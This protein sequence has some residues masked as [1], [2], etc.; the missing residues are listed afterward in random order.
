[1]YRQGIRAICSWL[2]LL[3][4]ILTGCAGQASPQT[5]PTITTSSESDLGTVESEVLLPDGQGTGGSENVTDSETSAELS[6]VTSDQATQ[7]KENTSSAIVDT[8]A[9]GTTQP[10]SAIA[11]T[12]IAAT[13][14]SPS[15]T[16]KPTTPATTSQ[17]TTTAKPTTPAATS[18]PSST[19]TTTAD[20]TTIRPTTRPTAA[21]S[22]TPE[23]TK[24]PYPLSCNFLIDCNNAVKAGVVSNRTILANQTVKFAEG[25][26]V[27]VVMKRLLSQK[28]ISMKSKGSGSSAYVSSINGLAEF[29]GGKGSGWMYNVNGWYPNY[30]C[31]SYKLKAGD[32]VEWR[33]TCDLG[34]DL[35]QS[36]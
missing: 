22:P 12:S 24:D 30:S 32:S 5:T 3:T 15:A 18:P 25:E 29:D 1:M 4:I 28:G 21:P 36:W 23:P 17:P 14:K 2:L 20:A 16:V 31:G 35:G 19:P 10:S 27:F 13:T 26:T 33:Y 11:N 9:A 8:S 34:K 6:T 7:D